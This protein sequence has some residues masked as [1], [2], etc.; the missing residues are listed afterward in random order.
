VASKVI[1]YSS[2]KDKSNSSVEI[3]RP[4]QATTTKSRPSSAMSIFFATRQRI[5]MG[6]SQKVMCVIIPLNN[7]HDFPHSPLNA[8]EMLVT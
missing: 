3:G 6:G 2:L 7:A 8:R 1:F 4:I 5:M